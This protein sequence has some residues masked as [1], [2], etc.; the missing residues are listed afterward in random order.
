MKNSKIN[1]VCSNHPN[2]ILR[3]ICMDNHDRENNL[4]CLFCVMENHR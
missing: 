3:F 1:D 2:Q 4:A